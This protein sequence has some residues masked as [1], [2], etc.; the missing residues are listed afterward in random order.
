[1]QKYARFPTE[2]HSAYRSKSDVRRKKRQRL[3]RETANFAR[4]ALFAKTPPPVKA[5]LCLLLGLFCLPLRAQDLI[6]L[7]SGQEI[8][9]RVTAISKKKIGYQLPESGDTSTVWLAT[10]DL[11][12]ILYED[13]MRQYFSVRASREVLSQDST[14]PDMYVLGAEDSRVYYRDKGAFWGPLLTTALIPFGGIAMGGLTTGLI[15]IVPPSVRDRQLPDPGT[16][17]SNPEYASGFNEQSKKKKNKQAL[18]G[19]GIGMIYQ[20]LLIAFVSSQ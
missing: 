12:M 1:M 7:G 11:D 2:S 3:R 20:V 5:T 4:F 9:A 8:S 6:L 18:K 15:L 13:G 19:F 16:Y 14:A 10:R 17:H